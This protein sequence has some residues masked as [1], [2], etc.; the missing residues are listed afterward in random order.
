M[1]NDFGKCLQK[2][3]VIVSCSSGR[4]LMNFYGGYGGYGGGT[5]TDGSFPTDLG[6]QAR[7]QRCNSGRGARQGKFGY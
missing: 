6:Q 7:H 4:A 2:S 3:H 5:E 1:T